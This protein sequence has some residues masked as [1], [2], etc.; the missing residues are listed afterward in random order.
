MQ[1][2]LLFGGRS[3][4][5]SHIDTGRTKERK[6]ENLQTQGCECSEKTM[7]DAGVSGVRC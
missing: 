3:L 6:T 5:Q 7:H 1:C 4:D 2:P